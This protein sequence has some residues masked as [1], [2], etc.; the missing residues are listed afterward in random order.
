MYGAGRSV[1]TGRWWPLENIF[2][3]PNGEA[4][5]ANERQF[6]VT[7]GV[8]GRATPFSQ[9][10]TTLLGRE[11]APMHRYDRQERTRLRSSES[12]ASSR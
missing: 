11:E 6:F 8:A 1:D 10:A 9:A 3:I 4:G 2:I 7:Y 5:P 12:P